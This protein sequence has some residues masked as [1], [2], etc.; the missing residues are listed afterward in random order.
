MG[1]SQMIAEGIFTD[2]RRWGFSQM[3]TEWDLL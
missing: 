2:D 3:W 1:F